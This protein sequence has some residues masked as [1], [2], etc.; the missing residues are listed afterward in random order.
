MDPPLASCPASSLSLPSTR[1]VPSRAAE[2]IRFQ[3]PHVRS[4]GEQGAFF[5]RFHV[6][7]PACTPSRF[8]ALTGRYAHTAR[9]VHLETAGEGTAAS[10]P[11]VAWNAYVSYTNLSRLDGGAAYFEPTAAAALQSEG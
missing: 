7:T 10:V 1:I 11:N 4:L 6:P 8:T 2:G 9:S 3:T 5:T